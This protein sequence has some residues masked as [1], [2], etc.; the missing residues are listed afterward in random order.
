[1]DHMSEGEM[2]PACWCLLFGSGNDSGNPIAF[3]DRE[4]PHPAFRSSG[5]M[6]DMNSNWLW[7]MAPEVNSWD[8][9]TK[10]ETI[11][12]RSTIPGMNRIDYQTWA[13]MVNLPW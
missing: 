9:C 1:M 2:R 5:T 6:E 7:V 8:F 4:V 10:K 12:R 11:P 3:E 13:T